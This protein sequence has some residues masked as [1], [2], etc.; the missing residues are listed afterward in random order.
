[1]IPSCSEEKLR[2]WEPDGSIEHLAR[3]LNCSSFMASLL[4]MRGV[5]A[6]TLGRERDKWIAPDLSYW[7]DNVDLG[8]DSGK[9]RDL[10]SGI[11]EG[12]NVV[13]YG[14]YDVDGI[15]ATASMME[16]ALLKKTRVRYYIPHRY[17]QGYG[18][19]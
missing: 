3:K 9:A 4:W 16:L 6:Q 11:G 13:V 15:A 17:N 12:D 18:F 2:V 10:W 7:L 19:H 8:A 5:D 14:D 1:M